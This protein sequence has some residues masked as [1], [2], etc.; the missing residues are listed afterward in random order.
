MKTET[1]KMLQGEL[2]DASDK[3]LREERLHARKLTRLYNQTEET[4]NE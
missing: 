4:D 2:Y 1:E 3:V